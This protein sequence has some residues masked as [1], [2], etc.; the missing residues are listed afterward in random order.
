MNICFITSNFVNP[1][2]GG[3]ERVTF[4]LCKALNNQGHC[5][6]ILSKDKPIHHTD[7]ATEMC[8]CFPDSEVQSINN[9]N[10]LYDFFTKYKI[11]FVVNNS[12][13]QSVFKLLLLVK[14][15]YSFKLISAIHTDPNASIKGLRDNWDATWSVKA[16]RVLLFYYLCRYFIRFYLRKKTQRQW[17]SKLHSDSDSIVLLSERFIQEFLGILQIKQSDKITAIANPIK[18]VDGISRKNK[19]KIVVWVGR[20]EHNAKRP[21]RIIKIW[22]K[23]GEQFKEWKLY[24]IGEGPMKAGLEK[25]CEN[26]N[27]SNVIF[28]GRTDPKA[29]YEKA[30]VLCMTSTYE[31]FGMVLIEALEYG[32]I[33]FAFDSYAAVRDIVLDKQSG[34]LIK[35][36]NLKQYSRILANVLANDTL[37]NK[38]RNQ[39]IS[40][41]MKQFDIDIIVRKWIKLF[42]DL[43][44]K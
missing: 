4:E 19:E 42:E 24:M 37:R 10:Y 43:K 27:I 23:I 30:E 22:E 38:I 41:D 29:Y 2:Q 28:T 25:Y 5:A 12:H 34:F 8:V 6:Y 44:S 20:M 11:D 36:F 33:P 16:K 32:V 21:D 13:H 3:I 15:E 31:G 9:I 17:Y 26:N 39:I 35:P 18:Q 1:F 40:L 14:K 7:Q